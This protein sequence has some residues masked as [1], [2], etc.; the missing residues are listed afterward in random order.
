M[1]HSHI[2]LSSY[3]ASVLWRFFDA[4]STAVSGRMLRGSSPGEENLTFLLCELLDESASGL[5][6]LEYSLAEAKEDLARSDAG[7]TVDV[8]FETHEHSKF[9]ESR[10]SGAD[11]GLVLSIDHPI[12]GRTRRAALLQAK[13]LFGSG[14]SKEYSLY[15]SYSSYEPRQAEFLQEL[16][17]RFDSW[18]A[19]FYLWYNPPSEGFRTAEAAVIRAYEAHSRPFI[20][21]WY[22]QHPFF[23]ELLDMGFP[24]GVDRYRSAFLQEPDKEEQSR[25]WRTR[26]PALRI[27]ALDVVRSVADTGSAP[28]LKA[29]YDALINRHH[30]ITFSPL[31]DFFLLAL[32]STRYG[33]SNEEW[34]KL[35]EGKKVPLP[36][37]KEQRRVSE[38][39]LDGLDVT[40]IPRHT[41]RVAVSSTLPPIG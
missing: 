29:F 18:N 25:I 4:V 17:A 31:A 26:Q 15:S 38:A 32:A 9:F 1:S 33:S 22:H 37:K 5:H 13:R 20:D 7:I 21:N 3:E 24:L 11:L 6:V 28:Q 23:D 39:I 2:A 41:L 36:P 30:N 14:R 27:S 40:P 12:L 35:A 19:I 8:A 16:A 10:F 34:I